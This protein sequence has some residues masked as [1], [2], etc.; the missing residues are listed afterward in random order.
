MII[1]FLEEVYPLNLID[2]GCREDLD[3]KWEP[4]KK[5]L[6]VVGFDLNKKEC[7][8]L[9]GMYNPFFSSKYLPYAIAE[10]NGKKKL[11][12]TNSPYCWSLLEPNLKWLRRLSFGNLFESTGTEKIETLTLEKIPEIKHIDADIIK[13]DTQGM[14]LPILKRAGS[15]LEKAFYVETETGF[16]ESYFGETTYSQIDQ[17][18]RSKNF[19]LFDINTDHR[20]PRKNI[21]K[22]NS[23]GEQILWCE[24]TW[25]KDYVTLY[26]NKMLN[27]K[28]ISR[29]KVLKALILCALQGCISYGL[30]LAFLFRK[31]DFLSKKE[32]DQLKVKENWDVNDIK[33]TGA[34]KLLLRKINNKYIGNV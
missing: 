18:M 1:K 3:P 17:F 11:Y 28:N 21:F 7:E 22:N 31:L 4:I 23:K 6:S 26:N 29:N 13:I 34:L 5:Y 15:V 33:K 27:G 20:V 30:E 10:R 2:I 24:A 8:R 9:S 12:K 19:M 16:L 14:E 25:L 32:L